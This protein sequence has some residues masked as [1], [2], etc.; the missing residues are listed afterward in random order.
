MGK[1]NDKCL[2]DYFDLMHERPNAFTQSPILSIVTDKQRMLTFMESTNKQLGVVYKSPFHLMVVD[3]IAGVNGQ[4]F[5]YE[6]LLPTVEKGAVVCLVEY[7]NKIVLERV[8][9]MLYV[10]SNLSCHEDSENQI[11]LAQIM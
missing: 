9:G 10:K 11:F 3:L 2:D 8:S 7:N 4:D 5:A 1:W 6:R